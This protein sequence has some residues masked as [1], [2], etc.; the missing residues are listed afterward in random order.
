MD[1]KIDKKKKKNCST[2][3]DNTEQ[4]HSPYISWLKIKLRILD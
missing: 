4:L 3:L 2:G 1:L